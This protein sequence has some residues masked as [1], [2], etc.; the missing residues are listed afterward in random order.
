MT[1]IAE[2]DA[3]YE[4]T[5]RDGLIVA[6]CACGSGLSVSDKGLGRATVAAWRTRHADCTRDLPPASSGGASDA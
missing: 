5:R 3:P 1:Q 6:A 2:N 4:V